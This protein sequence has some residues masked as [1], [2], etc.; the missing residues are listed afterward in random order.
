M[1][2]TKTAILHICVT[3]IN[4]ARL[5]QLPVNVIAMVTHGHGDGV[6]AHYLTN[7][8]FGELYNTITSIAKLLFFLQ[9]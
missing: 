5:G 1:D 6:Y 9:I 3:T 7:C 8:W 2:T 4:I